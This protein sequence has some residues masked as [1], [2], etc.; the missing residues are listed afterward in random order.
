MRGA[1]NWLN[2]RTKL[3]YLPSEKPFRTHWNIMY[4]SFL[5]SLSLT[6]IQSVVLGGAKVP[7]NFHHRILARILSLKQALDKW[8]VSPVSSSIHSSWL[9][10]FLFSPSSSLG[11]RLVMTT[12]VLSRTLN[13]KP[14]MKQTPFQD[15][16]IQY[17]KPDQSSRWDEKGKSREA[18]CPSTSRTFHFH[19]H[20]GSTTVTYKGSKV[21]ASNH[22]VMATTYTSCIFHSKTVNTT[23]VTDT[24]CGLWTIIFVSSQCF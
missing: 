1:G 24:L 16:F 23:N 17:N 19:M 4:C 12:V 6:C 8:I 11:R 20:P 3:I 14:N 7:G 9:A 10:F 2:L 13:L 21:N 22:S 18:T 5:F 15:C